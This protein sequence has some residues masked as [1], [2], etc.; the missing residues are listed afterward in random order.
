[1]KIATAI[2]TLREKVVSA[3][4][5]SQLPPSVVEPIL[6]AIYMQI[7]QAAAQEVEQAEKEVTDN[8]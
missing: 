4:N 7:A 3:I 8:G 5:E 2:K 1:M 6:N